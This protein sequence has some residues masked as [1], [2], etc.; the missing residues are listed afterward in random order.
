MHCEAR[1]DRES[2]VTSWKLRWTTE[3]SL[4]PGEHILGSSARADIQVTDRTVSRRHCS[5]LCTPASVTVR[6]LQSTNGTQ[7]DGKD[8]DQPTVISS[9]LDSSEEVTCQRWTSLSGLT[10]RTPRPVP[11]T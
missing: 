11:P 9:S 2:N 7:V 3:L 6:D 8:I 10:E 1:H 4:K 5:L